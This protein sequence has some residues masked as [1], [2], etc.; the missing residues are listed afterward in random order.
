[1][2]VVTTDG[3]AGVR[4]GFSVHIED[5]A[6]PALVE[7]NGNP[8]RTF[9]ECV[10]AET[11]VDVET[12]GAALAEFLQLRGLWTVVERVGNASLFEWMENA[13]RWTSMLRR[14]TVEALEVRFA[15]FRAFVRVETVGEVLAVVLRVARGSLHRQLGNIARDSISVVANLP[16]EQQT[17]STVVVR[18]NFAAGASHEPSASLRRVGIKS[19]V[20]A[21]TR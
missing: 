8:V 12:V 18:H 5:L 17:I 13:R 15:I 19:V 14:F 1:M 6:F 7:L 2:R 4:A 11:R 21:L 16:V 9:Y 10:A 3:A 20:L